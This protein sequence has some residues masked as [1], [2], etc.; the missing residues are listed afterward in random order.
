[1]SIL[2]EEDFAFSAGVLLGQLG[3]TARVSRDRP[4]NGLELSGAAQ[5]HRT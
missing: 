5:L 1:M 4:P 3:E 2:L